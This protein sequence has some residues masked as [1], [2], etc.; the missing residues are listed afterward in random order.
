MSQAIEPLFPPELL[1]QPPKARRDYFNQQIFGHHLFNEVFEAAKQV[2]NHAEPGR[3]I[4]LFGPTGIG[5]TTLKHKLIKDLMSESLDQIKADPGWLPIAGIKATAQDQRPFDWIDYYTRALMALN[6][7]LI[8]HKILYDDA[9]DFGVPE[10]KLND[11]GRLVIKSGTQ[12]RRLRIALEECLKHRRPKAFIIDEAPHLQRV[13]SGKSLRAQLDTLKSLAE[14]SGT[15]HLLLGTYD[16]LEFT[17]LN[18]QLGR[19]S[20]EI[21]FRRY[22]AGCEA[23]ETEFKRMLRS[24]E[25]IIPVPQAPNLVKQWEFFY[26]HSLGCIGLVKRWLSRAL[27]EALDR[28]EKTL[29][30]RMLR[31]H[32]APPD[33]LNTIFREIREGE[34]RLEEDRAEAA[35]E[36][37]QLL[38]LDREQARAL[39][40]GKRQKR[41]MHPKSPGKRSNKPFQRKPSRDPIG[42]PTEP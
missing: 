3:I 21:H 32:T 19:R 40:Q 33:K 13:S 9:I 5:K 41:K 11:Q 42:V 6:E 22:R 27:G 1:A 25:Y 15:L 20:E 2:I 18:G 26:E 7:P 29:T 4:L 35:Q 37:R 10:V 38:A 24:F 30:E 12:L 31:K 39:G 16:L 8:E 34:R 36:L 28:D 17:N 14:A 23:D